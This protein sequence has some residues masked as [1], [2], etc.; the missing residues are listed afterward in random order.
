MGAAG[1]ARTA[2]ASRK[3]DLQQDRDP[4]ETIKVAAAIKSIVENTKE[5]LSVKEDSVGFWAMVKRRLEVSLVPT[6]TDGATE[7]A[8]SLVSD[9]AKAQ[10]SAV[11]VVKSLAKNGVFTIAMKND[12]AKAGVVVPL[13]KL[14]HL[15]ANE[16]VK[17]AAVE[18]LALLVALAHTKN[19]ELAFKAGAVDVLLPLLKTSR[20]ATRVAAARCL[21]CQVRHHS[22]SMNAVRHQ[23]GLVALV[24]MLQDSNRP[25]ENDAGLEATG[26]LMEGN[27]LNQT[28]FAE[29]GLLV[30]LMD[31]MTEEDCRDNVKSALWVLT[32][33][34]KGHDRNLKLATEDHEV[35]AL[36]IRHLELPKGA[37][38]APNP[39]AS[40]QQ[41][42]IAALVE[43]V[44]DHADRSQ[45]A[46][47]YGA[48]KLLRRLT[49]PRH[50]HWR[51]LFGQ[52]PDSRLQ[53]A[54]RHALAML[55]AKGVAPLEEE[56]NAKK[57]RRKGRR[58]RG[59]ADDESWWLA[60]FAQA[61]PTFLGIAVAVLAVWFVD[62]IN[63]V[64]GFNYG[65]GEAG[66][67]NSLKAWASQV[68]SKLAQS[69]NGE[70]AAAAFSSEDFAD[71][72]TE[73]ENGEGIDLVAEG[74]VEL[75][76][77]ES[78]VGVEAATPPD[79]GS[80]L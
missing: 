1:L 70:S 65:F 36:V 68:E 73:V 25:E 69:N 30:P 77:S 24:E 23:G 61:F 67:Y 22:P 80:L 63:T 2:Y 51:A 19:Q 76:E 31:F 11:T 34:I 49:R 21:A 64:T 39:S 32:M 20:S 45:R 29:N 74:Y 79:R 33:L 60:V 43:F 50:F 59:G 72:L 41:Y 16:G 47:E 48:L 15:G 13:T 12:A 18:A 27:R 62:Y 75:V 42:A 6:A 8:S 55:G 71:F 44:R 35:L 17:A 66:V 58:R 3:K 10:R 26:W 52:Q 38:K 9:T 54:A 4:D 40:P 5:D 46:I 53:R 37:S 56:R 14:I 28:G 7:E 57:K 78:D